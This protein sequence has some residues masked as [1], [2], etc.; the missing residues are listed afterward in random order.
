[1]SW[2]FS[3][4]EKNRDDAVRAFGNQVFENSAHI[5]QAVSFRLEDAARA[6]ADS[7][8]GKM[9]VALSSDGHFNK[10]GSGNCSVRLI[11][12]VRAEDVPNV[13]LDAG[14]PGAPVASL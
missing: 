10:D 6:L 8:D 11:C 3:V 12:K 14:G 4:S 5:P 2:S 1:M 9:E 13:T 7:A